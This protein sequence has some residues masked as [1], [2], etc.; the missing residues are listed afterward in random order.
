[1]RAARLGD[2][3]VRRVVVIVSDTTRDEPRD[4]FLEALEP[5][6]DEKHLT[7]A[8]A[9]GTHGP[10]DS[11]Q[12]GLERWLDRA[13]VVINH[14]AFDPSELVVVG[15]SRRGTPFRLHRCIVRAD[16]VIATGCIKPHYFA[17]FGAGAKAIFPGLG[18]NA[19]IRRN[20]ELKKRPESRAGVVDGNPCREDLEEVLDHL[21]AECF[22]LNL[23]ANPDGSFLGAVAGDVRLA[24]RAGAELA[25][26][27][28][29]MKASLHETIVVSDVAPVTNS[30]YQ[31]S[32]LVAAAAPCLADGG[33][34]IVAA[35]CPE[36]IGPVEVVNHGIYE[37]GL[38]PRLPTNHRI[39]LVSSLDQS[40]VSSTYCQFAPSIESA[41]G[42]ECPLVVPRASTTILEAHDRD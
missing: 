9:N 23:V 20:H 25:R 17:G 4:M 7:L 11:R 38:K 1:M 42:D 22:L 28:F 32:K 5:H 15:H 39:V 16:L 34:I 12:L 37:L 26:A 3:G 29:T 6:L 13:D 40:Q 19:E 35:E 24:F 18:G 8:I 2:I 31:A 21:E 41:L 14:D 10:C 33:T 36:G 30:L 27:E